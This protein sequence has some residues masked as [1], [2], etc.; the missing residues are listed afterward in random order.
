MGDFNV[1]FK[2]KEYIVPKETTLQR[3]YKKLSK[4]G[5]KWFCFM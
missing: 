4:D 5:S 1:K 3:I 2:N